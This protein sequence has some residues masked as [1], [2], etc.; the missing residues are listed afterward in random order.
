MEDPRASI[1]CDDIPTSPRLELGTI[2]VTGATGYIGGRLVPELVARGYRVR[3]MVRSASQGKAE[4]F[5][6]AEVVVGDALEPSTLDGALRDVHTAF[7]LIHSLLLGPCEFAE[8]DVTA[9]QSFRAAAERAEVQRIVYLGGLGDCC[10]E[11][12]DHLRS[13]MEVAEA[14]RGDRVAVTV[15]RAAV[16]IGS[17]SASYEII[18]HLALR[19][20]VIL[21]PRW[22]NNLCQPIAIRDVV[23]YLVACLEEP[24]TAGRSFDIGGKDVLTYRA[25]LE[26]TAEIIQ[27]RRLFVS[28]PVSWLAPFGYLASLITPVPA[29]ITMCLMEGL[30]SPAVCQESEITSLIPLEL[31]SFSE[32]IVAALTRE[33]QDRVRTRWSDAYP[34]AHELAMKL[35]ELEG[36]ARYHARHSITSSKSAAALFASVCRVGGKEGWFDNNWMWWLRGVVDRLL[37]GV[38]GS[39]GRRSQRTLEINDV[40]DFWRVEDLD[41]NKRLLLRAEM[42]LPGKAWLEFRISGSRG[43][44]DER[45]RQLETV[46]HFEPQ[47]A[48]GVL[49]WY[50]FL[51]FHFVIFKDLL[52]QIEARAFDAACPMCA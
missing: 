4:R 43:G 50:F 19:L 47:G 41:P 11:L 44:A 29:A 25:M 40:I 5:G 1:F 15:L 23:R 3:V 14:L 7:Y 13:R 12:S 38:G 6:G 52:L 34:P 2:L 36:G 32:A 35:A 48:F 45:E 33:E 46:A 30:R 26:M 42:K 27:K 51:P 24:A 8:A 9:A 49:Y 20:P 21:V 16:I 22:A 28:S 17:G 10:S 39:R 31:T 37:L 18:K